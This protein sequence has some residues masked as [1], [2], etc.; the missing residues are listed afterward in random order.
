M[1][2]SGKKFTWVFILFSNMCLAESAAEKTLREMTTEK[3]GS[4]YH[5]VSENAEGGK[6]LERVLIG[7]PG[8]TVA[9]HTAKG[10]VLKNIG[11]YEEKAGGAAVPE[12]IEVRRLA[13]SGDEYN[14][15]WVISRRGQRIAY[16]V[17][18][19]P[20]PQGGVDLRIQGPWE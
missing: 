18:L 3:P 17:S 12:V 1:L 5:W 10:D 7:T 14:E 19:K 15:V 9:D 6:V 20:S 16:T 8:P 2:F 13:N 4:P 11:A